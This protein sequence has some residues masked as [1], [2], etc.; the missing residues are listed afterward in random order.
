MRE[1]DEGDG[2]EEEKNEKELVNCLSSNLLVSNLWG[3]WFNSATVTWKAYRI[4]SSA[5]KEN[6]VC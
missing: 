4:S 3:G 1:R 2:W 6:R 5:S